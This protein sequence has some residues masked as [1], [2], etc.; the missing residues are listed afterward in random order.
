VKVV[1]AQHL[2]VLG[3][4]LRIGER[5]AF[6]DFCVEGRPTPPSKQ[7]VRSDATV[8]ELF[9]RSAIVL[10]LRVVVAAGG[11]HHAF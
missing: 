7:V 5:S 8:M 3:Q 4:P 9:D 6:S 1:I 10:K 11:K 2:Q